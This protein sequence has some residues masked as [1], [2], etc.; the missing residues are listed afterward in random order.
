MD[1]GIF[2][3]RSLR[4]RSV[5]GD[6]VRFKAK[7]HG[8]PLSIEI[9]LSQWTALRER[10]PSLPASLHTIERLAADGHPRT[11]PEGETVLRV[12]LSK[13]E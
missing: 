1:S 7:R 2:I 3:V 11:D 6:F 10:C 4:P 9:S 8:R 5:S 12:T 13:A